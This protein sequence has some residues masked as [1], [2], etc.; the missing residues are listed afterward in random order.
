[1]R[2]P[3][4]FWLKIG[5]IESAQQLW[6]WHWQFKHLFLRTVRRKRMGQGKRRSSHYWHKNFSKKPRYV[7]SFEHA[8]PAWL[9][10]LVWTTALTR[11]ILLIIK[12]KGHA[13]LIVHPFYW[14]MNLFGWIALFGRFFD[15]IDK[16]NSVYIIG[17]LFLI[18]YDFRFSPPLRDNNLTFLGSDCTQNTP[19]NSG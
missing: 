5:Y 1:M 4:T 10:I 7:V 11:A 17:L 13:T 3:E 15:N 12:N 18:C 9:K 8:L 16:C 19:Y 6:T 2:K 14:I